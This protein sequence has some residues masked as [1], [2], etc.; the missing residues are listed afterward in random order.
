MT[1]GKHLCLNMIV[2]D[3]TANLERC[4][5][6]LAP[7][8]AC[9]VIGDAGSTDGTQDFIMA[10]FAERDL[11]GELHSIPFED[12]EQARNAAL[13]HAYASPLAY[14]Y[15]LLADPDLE[16]VVEDPDFRAR[17]EAPGYRL[18]QQPE[19][20]GWKTG[21]VR[22][23]HRARYRGVTDEDIDVPGEVE[24]LHGVWFRKHAAG[25]ENSSRQHGSLGRAAPVA[26]TALP[27][28][29]KT[30]GL[31]MIVKNE[32]HVISRCLESARRLVD[33]VLI[34]DTGST[35]D[36]KAIIHA[37]LDR[38]NLPGEIFDEPWR[39]FAHNRSI[40]LARLRENAGLDYALMMDAD[41][42]L[43][44]EDGFDAAAFKANLDADQYSVE[45]RGGGVRY[46]RGQIFSNRAEFRYRGVL[47][48]FAESP[49]GVRSATATG[50]HITSEREGARSKDP[51]KYH[52]DARL[53]EDALQSEQ[54][55]GVISRYTFYLAQSYRDA[56]R[57]AEAAQAYA[58]RADM[59]G[60]EE[61]AWYAR[62]M[63]ARCLRDL[64]DEGGFLRQA[65]AAYNQRP[66]RAEPLYDLARFYRDRGMHE[67][68]VL[69]SEPALAL[70]PPTGDV[71]FVEHFIYS[72]GLKEEYSIS[73]N[74]S[75]NRA[76]KDRGSAA[77]DWLAL[78]RQVPAQVRDLARWNL[79]FYIEP[80][81]VMMPSFAA[82]PVG[83]T[84]PDGYH[85]SNPSIA[86]CGDEI[87]MVQRTVNY[88][89]AQDGEYRTPDGTPVH[90]RNFL[91]RLNAE[92]EIL[93]PAEILPPADMPEPVN[94][95]ARGFED[96]RLFAW[97]NALW[98]IAMVRDQTPEGWCEQI[99]ARIDERTMGK[100]RM[101]NWRVLHPPG[102]ILHE[103]NWMPRVE[104]VPT[105][106]GRDR[107][108]FIYLC[109]PTRIV[110]DRAR[111]I[112]EIVP[113][114]AAEHFRGG[115]QAIAFDAC[116]GQRSEGG[117][118]ALIHEVSVRDE[119]R[120]YQHRFVWLDESNT[121]RGVSRP[122]Y[123][124]KKGIEFAAGLAWHPDGERLLISY[125]VDDGEA[126]LATVAAAEVR[127]LLSDVDRLPSGLPA[128][129]DQDLQRVAE[130]EAASAAPLS[131]PDG[132]GADTV[133]GVKSDDGSGTEKARVIDL[134]KPAVMPVSTLARKLRF[135]ILGIPHTAS[136]SEYVACAYTQ[137]VV[138]LCRMLKERGHTVIHYGNETSNVVCD[139]PVTVTTEDDLVRAYG[140]QDWK[141]NMF[142]FDNG[143][144]A[145]QTFYKN[146]IDELAKR[147]SKNDFLLCMWGGGHQPVAAAHSDMIV[148]EPGIGYPRGHFA[149]FKI[150]ESYAM[151]HAYHGVEAVEAA[152]K[153]DWYAAVI[154]NFF[155][156]D[157]FEFSAEK[158]DYFLFLGR[159]MFGKGVNIA[160]QVTQ[161][162]GARL[163]VAGQGNL[164]D[165]GY[166]KAP[167]N[168]EFVGFADI[169]TRKKLLSRAKGLFL[170]SLYIEPF[171]GVQ[172]EALLSGTPTITTDWG[173]FAENNLHGITGY[174]CRTFDHFAWAAENIDRIDPYM[175]RRWAENNFSVE[176]VGEMY[177]EYFQYVT[178]V[179]A[180]NG[181][182]Q[183][184]P[185]RANL[186]WLAKRFPE[187]A[188][189]TLPY[190]G[191][192]VLKAHQDRTGESGARASREES[193]MMESVATL[194][195]R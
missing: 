5:A 101:T 98:C 111:T 118:L 166:Q 124:Q 192:D 20:A 91:V 86:R 169:E 141:T 116:L 112:S 140:Y 14:D 134:P 41:D 188:A 54:D 142:R 29:V 52:K 35:D 1:N 163:I 147:K 178:D 99:L 57:K 121:L 64:D 72:A 85:L 19:R 11:P 155:N 193:Y 180:G 167:D 77:C 74:Y 40:V 37:F 115:S 119:R 76:R 126:W 173:A 10:F 175:C 67:A 135:H 23:D 59:G 159:V 187:Y 170:P 132:V 122:F 108:Q 130:P 69:F 4:L 161:Q 138:K 144:H 145:Y 109:D 172:I 28:A 31:C 164:A 182:Y 79:F 16:L 43:V 105:E 133:P 97:K 90:T 38:E 100:C 151:Y 129:R 25:A 156:L 45:L 123:F 68:S 181:W 84:P 117:W 61:E 56:G 194:Q 174:R 177:E 107:L 160:L 136:N 70:A 154:P 184:H 2:K 42:V 153:L 60:F 96:L 30:I 120:Y 92:L 44:F 93:S 152:N 46:L 65:L 157:E 127:A 191:A 114:I 66:A 39:D 12:F 102:E 183:R 33:Y 26:P 53:L 158:D 47:H 50:F 21:L 150:F 185:Q 179:F 9:W 131:Q 189:A 51:D 80:A 149:K 89:A 125:G 36:T 8:I 106:A 63:E 17:L 110:D 6:A 168:V 186:D 34:E 81:S 22:R 94:R 7:H 73:A 18:L 139:E 195:R 95:Q 176:R 27:R 113:S 171:G 3:E 13:D 104:P 15:L 49:P 146:T 83:H 148:V 24:Q 48:E 71:L 128:A 55:P 190:R 75:R 62:L 88:T 162:I 143:D 137:K 87:V 78:N 82:H 32:S 165:V 58:K 103:K